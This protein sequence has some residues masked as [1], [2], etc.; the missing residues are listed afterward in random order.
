MTP[1]V[2]NDAYGKAL[3]D[4]DKVHAVKLATEVCNLECGTNTMAVEEET[5]KVG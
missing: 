4:R 5:Y 2:L 1:R 3:D